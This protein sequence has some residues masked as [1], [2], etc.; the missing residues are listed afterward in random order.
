MKAF[1]FALVILS[2]L[3]SLVT[4]NTH[5]ITGTI[6]DYYDEIAKVPIPEKGEKLLVQALLLRDIQTAWRRD[7]KRISLTV[8]HQDLMAYE[9]KLSALIGAAKGDSYED[10]LIAR[11]ETLYTLSHLAD[12]GKA[13]IG[14]IL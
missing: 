11:E 14:N 1:L 9:E 5:Y 6:Q 10:Y 7:A 13:S 3:F 8:N 2:I 12:M 4:W